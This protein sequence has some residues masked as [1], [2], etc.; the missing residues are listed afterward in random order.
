MHHDPLISFVIPTKNRRG[1]LA[2]TLGSL[3][4]QSEPRWE[5]VVVD[6]GSTDGTPGYVAAVARED[7]R[8]RLLRRTGANP[9]AC[10]A[11]NQGLAAARA[12]LVVFLDSDDVMEPFAVED[13][14]APMSARPDLDFLVTQARCFAESPGDRAT[15]W[16][17]DLPSWTPDQDIDRFLARDIPWQ[18]T[19]ATWRRS[20]L[21]RVGPW[22]E[23]APSGQDLDFHLRALLAGLRYDRAGGYDFHWRIGSARRGSIGLASITAGHWAYRA[24]MLERFAR[25]LAR[26]GRLTRR[27]R[28]LLGGGFWNAADYVRQRAGVRDATRLWDR[29]RTLGLISARRWLEGLAYLL[30]FGQRHLREPAR[31]WIARSWPPE[32]RLAPSPTHTLAQI[33]PEWEAC[34]SRRRA[35]VGAAAVDWSAPARPKTPADATLAQG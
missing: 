24:V 10:A 22:D 1:L 3:F 15:L 12:D 33:P 16:N 28:D 32:L 21:A 5:A 23:R 6:D 25:L 19:G 2:E 4:A 34:A 8:V 31:R 35:A 7:D 17:V 30:G 9:G 27:R 18:T 13:R 29:A 14:L 11:R 26:A 20:A